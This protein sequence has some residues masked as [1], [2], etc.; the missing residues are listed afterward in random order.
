MGSGA[1]GE[2]GLDGAAFGKKIGGEMRLEEGKKEK[3]GLDLG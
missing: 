3:G 2:W 1:S